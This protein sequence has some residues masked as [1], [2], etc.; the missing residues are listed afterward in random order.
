MAL[1]FAAPIGAIRVRD[2]RDIASNLRF[3]IVAPQTRFAKKG[4][5]LR[6]PRAIRENQMIRANLGIDSC[7]SDKPM[8]CMQV[9]FHENDGNH[10]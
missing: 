7:E 1:R 10:E 9:A 2:S 8:V 6:N 3:A 4:V 5:Q